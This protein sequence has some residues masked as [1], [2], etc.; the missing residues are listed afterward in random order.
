M[1]SDL[2]LSALLCSSFFSPNNKFL[3][4]FFSPNNKFLKN[5]SKNDV[6]AE[7]PFA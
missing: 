3:K 4:S 6:V 5:S 1:R 7:I 2:C